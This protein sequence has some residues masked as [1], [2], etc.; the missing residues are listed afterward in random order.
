MEVKERIDDDRAEK[1]PL[2]ALL[3]ST[4]SKPTPL[5]SSFKF[6]SNTVVEEDIQVE[7]FRLL[8]CPE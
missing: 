2:L 1:V 8:V 3:H 7:L 4:K 5:E 6:A